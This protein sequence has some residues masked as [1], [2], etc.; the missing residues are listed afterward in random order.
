[1]YQLSRSIYGSWRLTSSRTRFPAER[2][3]DATTSACCAPCEAHDLPPRDGSPLLRAS[4]RGRC[5]ATIRV[6]FPIA[7]AGPR[8]ARRRPLHDVRR[9]VVRAPSRPTATTSPAT[10]LECRATTRK[11]T[12]C[13]RTPLPHNGYCPSHQHLAETEAT[14]TRSSWSSVD[15]ALIEWPGTPC[16]SASSGWGSWARA[17]PRTWREPAHELNV[18]NRTRET[19]E[20]WAEEH[21]ATVAGT[22]AR[23]PTARD[24]VITMVVDGAQVEEMLLGEDGAAAG[25]PEGRCS[26]TCRR[27]RPSDARRIGEHAHRAGPRLRRRARDRLGSEGRG[28]HAHDHVRRQRRGHASAPGRCSRRWARRSSTPARSARARRSR[29]SPTRVSAINCADARPGAGGRPRAPASTSR[30]CSR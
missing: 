30:R 25:A 22:P 7:L 9:R 6:Y 23:P 5:S 20:A 13:Q 17:R 4:R 21:G 14:S 16:A 15:S 3:A 26:S 1:M 11:G 2:A 27:S 8:L 28:R 19:A 24:A 18:F 12:P 29:S 10:A